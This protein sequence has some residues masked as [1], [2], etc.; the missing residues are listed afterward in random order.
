MK[1]RMNC[2]YCGREYNYPEDFPNMIYAKCYVCVEIERQVIEANT[3]VGQLNALREAVRAFFKVFTKT[4]RNEISNM[5]MLW[6]IGYCGDYPNSIL[7]NICEFP[8]KLW[9]WFKCKLRRLK[10]IRIR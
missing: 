10:R 7:C 5:K 4:Y 9:W 6:A 3:M 2:A 1:T 8:T